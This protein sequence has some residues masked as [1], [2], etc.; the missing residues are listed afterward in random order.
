[1]LFELRCVVV[2]TPC[3]CCELCAERRQIADI[4]AV[5]ARGNRITTQLPLQESGLRNSSL[6]TKTRTRHGAT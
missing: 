2:P 5:G 4:W 3:W 1:M 6:E